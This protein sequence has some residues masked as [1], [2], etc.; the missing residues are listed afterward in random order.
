MENVINYFGI[1]LSVDVLALRRVMKR[2]ENPRLSLKFEG[3]S[4][5]TELS[6]Y[7]KFVSQ[8]YFNILT[9]MISHRVLC[10]P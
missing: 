10:P 4:M 6:N 3:N 7:R 8:I 5:I 2:Q 1:G 9:F